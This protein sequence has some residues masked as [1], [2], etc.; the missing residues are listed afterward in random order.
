M[1]TSL[2]LIQTM[3]QQPD[4][5]SVELPETSLL[6]AHIPLESL[7]FLR[8]LSSS[9]SSDSLRDS[10]SILRF[11]RLALFWNRKSFLITRKT[12]REDKS[13]LGKQSYTLEARST[14][15]AHFE[16][17]LKQSRT[18]W[19]WLEY[20]YFL[21]LCF[22]RFFQCYTGLAQDGY[23]IHRLDTLNAK[24]RIPNKKIGL[25]EW[26]NLLGGQD[27]TALHMSFAYPHP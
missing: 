1:I 26:R 25:I 24:Y 5:F 3:V 17:F 20:A 18:P 27:Y 14:K 10:T 4:H 11:F 8:G 19:E 7:A 2:H 15:R 9:P 22:R 6:A 21:P 23:Q 13:F 12:N 16:C